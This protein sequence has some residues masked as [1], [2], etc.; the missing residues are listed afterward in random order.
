MTR[1]PENE[2]PEMAGL[3]DYALDGDHGAV[4]DLP[5]AEG[6]S[7]V[8]GA[9]VAAD[10]SVGGDVVPFRP[11]AEP[12]PGAKGPAPLR[13]R[14]RPSPE[15]AAAN[16]V[17]I[18]R[19]PRDRRLRRLRRHPLVR[20]IGPLAMAVVIVSIPIALLFWLLTSPRFALEGLEVQG[21][22]RRVAERWVERAVEP[23][24]GRN[25][26]LLPLD[27][28][29]ASLTRNPWVADVGLVKRPPATLGIRVLERREEALYRSIDGLVYVDG[30]GELIAPFDPRRGNPDLPLLTGPETSLGAAL[31]LL[32]E[33]AEVSPRWQ[34]GLSEVEILSDRDFRVHSRELAFPLLVRAGTLARKAP[35]LD[36][37][38]PRILA[39]TGPVSEVDLRFTRR[40]IVQPV[41][42]DAW[43]S[44]A[45]LETSEQTHAQG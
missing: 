20:W 41:D 40:I 4:A 7:P 6:P 34:P 11:A 37:L 22:E 5:V 2:S 25:V 13:G 29:R 14:R 9:A 12:A 16:V 45:T 1:R 27:D 23:Y 17:P 35:R 39:R 18:R 43:R 26:W 38:L 44:R 19:R 21:E 31:G 36:T 28:V 15:A 33:I 10:G 42:P 24:R 8:P 32:R 30:E 3:A